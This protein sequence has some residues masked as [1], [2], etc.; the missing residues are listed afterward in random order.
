MFHRVAVTAGYR[1]SR[2]KPQSSTLSQRQTHSTKSSA[3]NAAG[4]AE[5]KGR[6]PGLEGR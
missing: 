3:A 1:S 2:D 6:S 5:S 4:G